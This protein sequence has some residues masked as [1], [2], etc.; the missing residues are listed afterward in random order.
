MLPAGLE[1]DFIYSWGCLNDVSLD[2][3][4]KTANG[5]GLAINGS[6]LG[7][8]Q[9]YLIYVQLYRPASGL[10]SD[11]VFSPLSL[12]PE[13]SSFPIITIDLPEPPIYRSKLAPL[14][15][16]AAASCLA[17]PVPITFAWTV[18]IKPQGGSSSL[19]GQIVLH[20]MGST[21]T[22]DT[23]QVVAGQSYSVQL[24]ALLQDGSAVTVVSST[25]NIESEGAV[26]VLDNTD[27]LVGRDDVIYLNASAS[28]DPD[29][30]VP[31]RVCPG[32]RL[33]GLAF[34][35][36][37]IICSTGEACRYKNL[38]A[39]SIIPVPAV[40]FH[41]SMLQLPPEK[42]TI[43]FE[44]EVVKKIAFA[45]AAAASQQTVTLQVLPAGIKSLDIEIQLLQQYE[46]SVIFSA[47]SSSGS[48]YTWALQHSAAGASDPSMAG[49]NIVLSDKSTFPNGDKK[50][51]FVIDLSTAWAW[52]EF[53]VGAMYVVSVEVHSASSAVGFAWMQVQ[54]PV[55]PSG[56]IC[57]LSPTWGYSLSTLFTVSCRGW[58]SPSPP[59]QYQFA[60]TTNETIANNISPGADVSKE[61]NWTPLGISGTFQFLLLPGNFS[62]LVSVVD[63]LVGAYNIFLYCHILTSF[64]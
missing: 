13:N 1:P 63:V 25:F 31:N 62:I 8:G 32:K 30:C 29:D 42:T 28:Y 18:Q 10:H 64:F 5:P 33:E 52:T 21:L 40:Y 35:W 22:I 15:A 53:P 20:A 16:H 12:A 46:K 39:V 58:S 38:S 9:I 24:A 57:N 6:S 23:S 49:S 55:P 34:S 44:V 19:Q 61:L 45:A 36:T 2:V 7:A 14:L 48:S 47:L 4:L 27:R 17:S 43:Q 54:R 3:A 60:V 41:L 11:V 51:I 26:A 59:I 50:N 37:C 56:G